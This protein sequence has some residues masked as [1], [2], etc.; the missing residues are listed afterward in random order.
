MTRFLF[1][2][3]LR[4]DKFIKFEFEISLELLTKLN[5]FYGSFCCLFTSES[6]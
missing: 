6:I 3:R 2:I 5:I 4:F 1:E